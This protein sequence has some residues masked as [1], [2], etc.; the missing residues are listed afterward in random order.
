MSEGKL[1]TKQ[2][3]LLSAM[4]TEP[5]FAAACKKANIG[6]RTGERYRSLPLFVHEYELMKRQLFEQSS[7]RLREL[8]S[9]SISVLENILDDENATN[10]DKI[11]VAKM[12]LDNSFRVAEDEDIMKRL[13]RI[14]QRQKDS[15]G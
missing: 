3:K 10:S 12:L 13:D 5:T 15:E 7:N 8:S 11:K 1:T 4:F 14:E 9:K 6:Q 2:L